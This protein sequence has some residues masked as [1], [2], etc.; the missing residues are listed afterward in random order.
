MNE[1]GRNLPRLEAAEKISGRATY[2]ADLY[3]PGMLH[4]AILKSPYAHARIVSYEISAALALPGVACVLTGRDFA[5]GKFGPFIKDECVLA[6]DKVR[7]TGEAVCIVAA[8]D[9]ATARRATQL[10][11]VTYEELPAVLSPEEAMADDAPLVHEDNEKNFRVFETKC[12]GNLAWQVYFSEGDVDAAWA[13]CDVIVENEFDTQAQ[14]HV[15]I[16]PCGALAEVDA[17]G[18]VTI[19]S[20]NQSVFRVQAN[21][22]DALSLPMSKVRCVTPRVGGG[23]GNKMELHVQAMTAALA[24]ATG[25]PVK[26]VLTREEDFELVR[27]RHPYKIRARTG[28]RRDGTLLAREVEAVI[29]CGA[30]GDDSPGVMGFSLWMARG[31]YRIANFRS[32]GRLYYTNKLRFGAFRGFGNPQVTFAT[33]I[34][35]DEIATKLGIDPFDLREKNAVR[36]GDKWVGGGDIHSDGFVKCLNSA[37]AASRWDSRKTLAA[38]PGRRRALGVASTAHICG[39]LATGAIVRLLEDGTV[40]LNTGAVDIGQG[41]D[42]VLTQI[43]ADALQ[44]SVDRVALASPDTDGSPFNWGTTASRVTYMTGRAVLGAAGNV[45][46]KIKEHAAEMLECGVSDLEVRQ[47]GRVGIVGIPQKEVSFEDVSLRAH[48][49]VGGPIIGAESLIYNKPTIDPKRTIVSGLPFPQIGVFSF[50]TVV[51][52]VE[53]DEATGKATVLEAWSACDIGKA[54]NPMSVEGQIQ[55]GFVQGMGFA[56][57]EEMVWDGARIANP[58]LMDYKIATTLDVP[59]R[60]HPLLIEDPEPDGPFGAKGIGEI[61]ICSVAPAIANA[62]TAAVD[63]RLRKLP[64]TPERILTGMLEREKTV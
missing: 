28:A 58:S 46:D 38:A 49:A 13:A 33:E 21:V 62:I 52:D 34:Q 15:A 23:F 25:K 24:L 4:G 44:I 31:P 35:L 48:W 5:G 9:E 51:C 10:I 27:L 2:I 40:V 63:I 45:L 19:W 7:F 18:R 41:S 55:G 57:F 16:E 11:D 12:G 1:V 17:N 60:I 36:A 61:P 42:T 6:K 22:C 54:I 64:L 32:R 50:N 53:I 56:L 26:M 14:A 29:D 8:E 20:A 43:C 59:H 37:R 39:L 47:G 3:R 30:Y